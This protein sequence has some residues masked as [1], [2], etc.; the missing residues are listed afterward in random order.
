MWHTPNCQDDK[1]SL[2][3]SGKILVGS[4]TRSFPSKHQ[5]HNQTLCFCA[6]ITVS[7]RTTFQNPVHLHQSSPKS[8]EPTEL[9]NYLGFNGTTLPTKSARA[10][11]RAFP[12][13]SP[14]VRSFHSEWEPWLLEGQKL[15]KHLPSFGLTRANKNL[16]KT[17][18]YEKNHCSKKTQPEQKPHIYPDLVQE[19]IMR[20]KKSNYF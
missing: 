5:R 10:A 8:D 18:H 14:Q 17:K 1:L 15:Q 9:I 4:R 7:M 19:N 12:T 13:S 6:P 16:C 3:S 2:G 20:K 11:A